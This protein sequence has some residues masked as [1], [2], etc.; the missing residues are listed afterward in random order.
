MGWGVGMGWGYGVGWCDLT[1]NRMLVSD[2]VEIS[3]GG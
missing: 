1:G 2:W 3:V